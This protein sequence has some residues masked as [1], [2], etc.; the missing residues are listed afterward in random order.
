M[1]RRLALLTL[2]FPPNT[3]GVQTLLFEIAKR[4]NRTYDVYVITPVD[5]GGHHS[6]EC[7]QRVRIE[8]ANSFTFWR[9]LQSIRPDRV[10]LGHAH[11]MLLMAA[12]LSG[13][14]YYGTIV[15]G[16]DFLSAQKRWH[17]PLF[18]FL[19][20]RS[21]PLIAN[22]NPTAERL[23]QLGFSNSIVV[24]PGVDIVRFS[25]SDSDDHHPPIILTIGRLVP[26]KGIDLVIR[27]LPIVLQR[28]PDLI[29]RVGGDGPDRPRLEQLAAEL[30]VGSAVQFLGPIRNED[31]T[32]QYRSADIFV[33][34]VRAD[35]TSMEGFGIVYLEASA[36]GLPLIAGRSGG[37]VDAVRENETGML[38]DPNDHHELAQVILE[39]LLNPEK[40]RRMGETGRRWTVAEMSWDRTAEAIARLLR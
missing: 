11:P 3:G 40:R 30:G 19:L 7:F 28:V 17:R 2:D 6:K 24:H 18:N 31:L 20:G 5:S 13:I 16:S 36:C 32:L 38:V 33:M 1:K 14:D 34:P 10:L 25:P 9:V 23:V 27:S 4:L 15:H 35:A 21:Q 12:V 39:L 37:A 8:T 22:S 29:Y 26:R